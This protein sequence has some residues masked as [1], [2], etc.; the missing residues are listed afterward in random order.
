MRAI[1]KFETCLATVIAILVMQMVHAEEFKVNA[2]KAKRRPKV[3]YSVFN[4][5]YAGDNLPKDISQFDKMTKTLSE[6]GNFNA[7]MG[8]YT[9]ERLE[10]CRKYGMKMMVDLLVA[11]HHVYKNT[12]GYQALL[13]KLQG[14]ETVFAY[15]VWADKFGKMGAGRARDINNVHQWDPTHAT[16]IGTYR[17][18]G[19]RHLAGSDY[20]SYYD[21]HWK[22]GPDG[23]FPHLLSALRTAQSDDGRVGRYFATDP[24][25]GRTGEGNYRRS[26]Y[27]L[28]TSIAC[29]LKACMWFIGSRIMN[30]NTQELNGLG[31]DLGR[32][33]AWVMPM[34]H[35]IPKLGN[36]VAVYSTP[37]T[38]SLKNRAL[39]GEKTEMMPPGLSNNAI[40]KDFWVQA[41]SGEFAMGVFKDDEGRDAIYL[42]N[43]NTY[44]G[45]DVKLKISNGKKPS[46]FNRETAKWEAMQVTENS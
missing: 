32:V 33:N 40:P 26:L 10:I 5:G 22:R 6:Q 9:A 41:D 16:Y 43:H 34:K 37:I 39:P 12:K 27:S 25:F 7:I 3:F 20:I 4:N 17:N 23:N 14:N 19:I 31:K 21:F 11:D 42:A 1:E 2:E 8:M 35:E 24:S 38:K 45:Q 46:F 15:H 18:G 36:P 44:A 29:G 28:N 30:M 13:K